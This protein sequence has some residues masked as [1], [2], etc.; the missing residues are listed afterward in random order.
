MTLFRR[1]AWAAASFSALSFSGTAHADEPPRWRLDA[2]LT[3][4][5]FEQ[6]VKNEVGGTKGDLLVSETQ[7]GLLDSLT[8]RF[9]GPLSAGAYFQLDAGTREAGRFTGLDANQAAVVAGT[10]GGSYLEFWTGPLVRA[11]Y[12][13]LFLELGY[14]LYGARSDKA[15]DDLPNQNNSTQGALRT[16]PT[17][18]WMLGIGGG[19]PIDERFELALRLQYRVRYYNRRDG[20]KLQGDLVHGTQNFTSFA[21]IVWHIDA[22]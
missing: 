17:I 10:V 15:R 5:R 22:P 21:G 20:E 2:G 18:A 7:F 6:Q 4:S 14:G 1:A 3:F 8:Y 9:W 13:T 12:K 11:H 19:V 16:H